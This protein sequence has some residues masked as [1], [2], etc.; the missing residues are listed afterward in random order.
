MGK[1]CNFVVVVAL[2]FYETNYM[3]EA[4]KDSTLDKEVEIITLSVPSRDLELFV[5]KLMQLVSLQPIF[6]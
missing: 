4:I 3:Q 5:Q 6:L 2:K 1:K